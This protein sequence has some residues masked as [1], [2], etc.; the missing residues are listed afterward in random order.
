MLHVIFVKFAKTALNELSELFPFFAACFCFSALHFSSFAFSHPEM[1]SEP[2]FRR[3]RLFFTAYPLSLAGGTVPSASFLRFVFATCFVQCF[4]LHASSR[5]LR[6]LLQ[7]PARS[8]LSRCL[9]SIFVSLFFAGGE[10]RNVLFIRH[11]TIIPF[12]F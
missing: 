8:S 6:G 11:L 4:P 5:P 1:C 12:A 10:I 7:T 9:V 2:Q 3:A